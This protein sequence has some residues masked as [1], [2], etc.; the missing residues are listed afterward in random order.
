MKSKIPLFLLFAGIGFCGQIKNTLLS[1]LL[2]DGQSNHYT[3][4][5]S[6]TFQVVST[7]KLKFQDITL[8]NLQNYGSAYGQNFSGIVMESIGSEL[9]LQDSKLNLSGQYTLTAGT[10]VFIGDVTLSGSQFFVLSS[11][12]NST[13]QSNSTLYLDRGLTFSFG[14]NTGTIH[15]TDATSKIQVLDDAVFSSIQTLSLTGGS[16]IRLAEEDIYLLGGQT[17]SIYGQNNE[18]VVQ[19]SLTIYGNLDFVPGSNPELIITFDD[20]E[21]NPTV[22]IRNNIDLWNGARLTFRGNG[23]VKFEDGRTIHMHGTNDKDVC[24]AFIDSAIA[25][26]ENLTGGI[27]ITSMSVYGKGVLFVDNGGRILIEDHR[28]FNLGGHG[29]DTDNLL[30]W[31]DRGGSIEANGVDAKFKA[32]W[33]TLELTVQQRAYLAAKNYGVVE[34]NTS[35][36]AKSNNLTAVTFD[37]EGYLDVEDYGYFNIGENNGFA[38]IAWNFVGGN[39]Q[40]DGFV[41]YLDQGLFQGKL[42][43]SSAFNSGNITSEKLVRGLINN[44]VSLNESTQFTDVQGNQ[45]VRIKNKDIRGSLDN[46]SF[47]ELGSNDQVNGEDNQYVYG[48]DLNSARGFLIGLD[49][50]RLG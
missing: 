5:P 14:S 42:A 28:S 26:I 12:A 25:K 47:Y 37:Q 1:D 10:W 27:N 7:S 17:L 13:I 21:T 6:D 33:A 16:F 40:G 44:N 24:L 15:L 8:D 41:Q 18:I 11:T 3:L 23:I 20:Q 9:T 50:Q 36:S 49:G 31:I 22:Y 45:K 30:I 19:K 48:K 2:I 35:G 4:S 39:V 34:F 46:V 29:A 43:G 38:N 32:Y